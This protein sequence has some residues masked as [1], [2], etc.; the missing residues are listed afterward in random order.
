MTKVIGL[1]CLYDNISAELIHSVTHVEYGLQTDL[2]ACVDQVRAKK[3]PMQF[4]PW[5][6]IRLPISLLDPQLPEKFEDIVVRQHGADSD[7]RDYD[8]VTAETGRAMNF[9]TRF[10]IL[11]IKADSAKCDA[12]RDDIRAAAATNAEF[13]ASRTQRERV[14]I[15]YPAACCNADSGAVCAGLLE[16]LLAE[17][18]LCLSLDLPAL[19]AVTEMAG[20]DLSEAMAELPLERVCH[21]RLDASHLP[22]LGEHFAAERFCELQAVTYVGTDPDEVGQIA[23]TLRSAGAT[24]IDDVLSVDYYFPQVA[25]FKHAGIFDSA[26]YCYQALN[27]IPSYAANWVAEKM[28]GL[29][30]LLES[31]TPSA[32]A[33]TVGTSV[34]E[35]GASVADGATIGHGVI[36]KAGA[37]IAAG[38]TVEDGAVIGAN[39]YVAQGATIS[40]GRVEDNVYVGKNVRIVGPCVVRDNVWLDDDAALIRNSVIENLCYVAAGVLV[41]GATMGNRVILEDN[42]Q[43][44]PGAYIRKDT[45]FGKHVVF[46][47]EGKNTVIMD[48]EPVL[49]PDS[50][51]QVVAGSE[52]GH[53][54]YCGDSILG[55]L[56]NEG[57][58]DKNSNVKNDWGE[59]RVNIDGWKFASGLCKFGAIIGDFTTVGCLTV[60]E[61]GTLIGRACN[62]YGSKLRYWLQTAS[63]YAEDQTPRQR[64]ADSLPRETKS[65]EGRSTP[66]IQAI[67]QFEAS[68][69]KRVNVRNHGE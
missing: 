24:L 9:T 55:R 17:T 44:L 50:G 22:L 43:I 39:V 65:L 34:I 68:S 46:R 23:D 28:K 2:Q 6:I 54:G 18:A 61:P 11:P 38:A 40:G 25:Q 62:V 53:Y 48:G 47:S 21:L 64:W 37:V 26:R 51:K 29:Q 49:D 27:N 56:V 5:E 63:I 57:A 10:I 59:A 42:C 15:S 16:S 35:A 30:P 7:V 66:A 58:G 8:R 52:S 41:D 69:V 31:A 20:R 32:E 45:I 36:I 4:D 14:L 3:A 19:Q 12:D 1:G 13:L 67:R 33:K 60:L